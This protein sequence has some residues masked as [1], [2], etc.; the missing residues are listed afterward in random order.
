[1]KTAQILL[2]LPEFERLVGGG[3]PGGDQDAAVGA[4][5][6]PFRRKQQKP[7]AFWSGIIDVGPKEREIVYD[8][9]DYFNGT[10][11]VMAVVVAPDALG[12]FERRALVRGDFVIS[13]NTPTFLAPGDETEVS[14][15]V[16]NNVV[17]SGKGGNVKLALVASAG[18]EPLDGTERQLT[19]AEM[20]EASATFKLR[21]RAQVGPATL[22][23]TA[24][25]GAAHAQQPANQRASR[26]AVPDD[27]PGRRIRDKQVTVRSR[28]TFTASPSGWARYLYCR[29]VDPRSAPTR[30]FPRVHRADRAGRCRRSPA[31]RFAFAPATS[32]AAV[33]R[34][35]NLCADA[36]TRTAALA[37]GPRIRPSTSWRRSGRSTC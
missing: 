14:V 5:L 16:A 13:P 27:L 9:P 35:V 3:A 8:V 4:N 23:F 33:E 12:A 25:L 34:F 1:M 24:S 29:Q 10:L 11:R 21:A 36:R 32:A 15:S 37:A 19:I 20:R 6:N 26:R 18:I 30:R 31:S 17:G 22:A 7:V 28:G 2:I